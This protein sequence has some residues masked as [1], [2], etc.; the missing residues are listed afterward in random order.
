VENF[1][2][3]FL[4]RYLSKKEYLLETVIYLFFSRLWANERFA[5]LRSGHMSVTRYI[6]FGLFT[7]CLLKWLIDTYQR[8]VRT[9]VAYFGAAVFS[10]IAGCAWI[11]FLFVRMNHIVILGMIALI[12][13]EQLLLMV[14]PETRQVA[15][16]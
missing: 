1:S 6:E 15:R 9:G 14:L 16:S 10:I 13:A 4:F 5:D 7:L 12:I 11:A 8:S 3:Q 2:R